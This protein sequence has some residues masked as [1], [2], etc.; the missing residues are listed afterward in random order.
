MATLVFGT[1][2]ASGNIL[3]LGSGNWQPV[4]TGT[5]LYTIHI[6]EPTMNENTVV[7]CSGYATE[8]TGHSTDNIFTAF[9]LKP[10]HSHFSVVSY[11]VSAGNLQD[12]DFS[13]VAL[14]P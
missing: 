3:V 2:D 8:S 11:D 5:G 10:G 1:V 4:K 7:L 6:D 12:A 14:I 9:E 13:F